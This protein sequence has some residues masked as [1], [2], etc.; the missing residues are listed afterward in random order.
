MSE[1]T[2]SKF[3]T[4]SGATRKSACNNKVMGLNPTCNYCLPMPTQHAIPLQSVIKYQTKLGVNRHTMQCT[5]PICMAL[6]VW[7]VSD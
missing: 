3:Y 6:Q 2:T 4:V 1:F 5:S 7:L